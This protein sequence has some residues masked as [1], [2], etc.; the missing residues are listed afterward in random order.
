MSNN[1][2]L[3]A[4]GKVVRYKGNGYTIIP[5]VWKFSGAVHEFALRFENNSEKNYIYVS[6]NDLYIADQNKSR[7]G[8]YS[9]DDFT[10]YRNSNNSN[11]Y[12]ILEKSKLQDSDLNFA[13]VGDLFEIEILEFNPP[14]TSFYTQY[15][16]TFK[17][18]TLFIIFSNP[19]YYPQ[20]I[21]TDPNSPT[22]NVKADTSINLLNETSGQFYTKN[23]G[24]RVQNI[25]ENKEKL[26]ELMT[27]ICFR[28]D[29]II[30]DNI[31]EKIAINNLDIIADPDNWPN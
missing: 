30:L 21:D 29:F 14:Y 12:S 11:A 15:K 10:I 3:L 17:I 6:N 31:L 16:Y 19:V 24:E 8:F 22:Y 4:D 9:K 5:K 27:L 20:V 26:S 23:F 7:S 28:I 13:M 1:V 2:V 25:P 18:Q